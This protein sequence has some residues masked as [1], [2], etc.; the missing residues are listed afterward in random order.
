M[1]AI[2]LAFLVASAAHAACPTDTDI[3]NM[4]V[5]ASSIHLGALEKA[6]LQED[7]RRARACEPLM[8]EAQKSAMRQQAQD[9]RRAR[10]PVIPAA[11]GAPTMITGC[12]KQGCWGSDGAR[13]WQ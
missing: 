1:K 2:A 13:Y 3:R 8:T 12:D 9:D 4:E 10:R 7:I 11:G 5:S 6:V